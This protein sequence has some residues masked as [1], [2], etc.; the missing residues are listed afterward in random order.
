MLA[1]P[2]NRGA[3]NGVA[4]GLGAWSKPLT[5]RAKA[6]LPQRRALRPTVSIRRQLESGQGAL[7]AGCPLRRCSDGRAGG[8]RSPGG[9]RRTLGVGKTATG[10]TSEPWYAVASRPAQVSRTTGVAKLMG[11]LLEARFRKWKSFPITRRDYQAAF[12]TSPVSDRAFEPTRVRPTG[13]VVYARRSGNSCRQLGSPPLS[14]SATARS[15]FAR[16]SR[17]SFVSR[18]ISVSGRP[19]ASTMQRTT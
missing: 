11:V 17:I 10:H 3:G 16:S 1:Q 5:P 4:L 8:F 7:L 2:T 13:A 19:T 12:G 9:E 6:R 18:K 15:R 14:M